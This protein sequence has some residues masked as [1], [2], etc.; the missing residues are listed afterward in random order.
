MS[1][2]DHVLFIAYLVG[3]LSVGVYHFRRNRMASDYYVGG[4]RL[5]AHHVG[6][7]IVVRVVRD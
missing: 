5:S 6:L 2:V 4:R 7:S 1:V 3:I